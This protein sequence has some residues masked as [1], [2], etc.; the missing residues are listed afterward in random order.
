MYIKLENG[1]YRVRICLLRAYL[2]VCIHVYYILKNKN[3][4]GRQK[5]HWTYII[6][7]RFDGILRK[8][9]QGVVYGNA[10]V[11]I[12]YTSHYAIYLKIR[13]VDQTIFQISK[14]WTKQLLLFYY[15]NIC[16][17]DFNKVFWFL[18]IFFF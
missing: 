5:C 7:L 3:S 2:G 13:C 4:T 9:W 6:F 1:Y 16:S 10:W 18:I 15:V 11:S 17:F 14:M 12:L 8:I